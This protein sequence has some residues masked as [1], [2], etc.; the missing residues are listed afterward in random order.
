MAATAG[1]RRTADPDM[2]RRGVG[3][4]GAEG[5]GTVRFTTRAGATL[6]RLAPLT[7]PAHPKHQQEPRFPP[8]QREVEVLYSTPARVAR[9]RRKKLERSLQPLHAGRRIKVT[10]ADLHMRR[11][12]DHEKLRKGEH[13]LN[14]KR[15]DRQSFVTELCAPYCG[16]AQPRG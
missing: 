15:L 1:R 10:V 12:L 14:V 4:P 2:S 7:C 11:L 9:T 16:E 6:T 8:F 13:R 3:R 5:N